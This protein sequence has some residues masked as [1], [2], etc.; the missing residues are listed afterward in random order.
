MFRK[1]LQF[2]KYFLD[3][4][5]G[6]LNSNKMQRNATLISLIGILGTIL[7]SA[8]NLILNLVESL[9]RRILQR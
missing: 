9:C 3:T 8:L 5:S 2:E 4:Q 7:K 6:C 1:I